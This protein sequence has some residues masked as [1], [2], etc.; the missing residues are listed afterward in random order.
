VVHLDRAPTSAP[1]GAAKTL[2]ALPLYGIYWVRLCYSR[3]R[4]LV[5]LARQAAD[6]RSILLSS[7]VASPISPTPQPP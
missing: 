7:Q 1:S 5:G 3:N 2:I 4:Q 6:S